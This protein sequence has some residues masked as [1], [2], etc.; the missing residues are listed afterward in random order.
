[1]TRDITPRLKIANRRAKKRYSAMLEDSE[2]GIGVYERS[3]RSVLKEEYMKVLDTMKLGELQ[4]YL[5]KNKGL[6]NSFPLTLKYEAAKAS[7][8]KKL[9]RLEGIQTNPGHGM[10]LV[11][12]GKNPLRFQDWKPAEQR[13]E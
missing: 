7:Y 13:E 11:L 5:T 1:M 4:T 6:I 10:N 12:E 8:N 9:T 2:V 3:F